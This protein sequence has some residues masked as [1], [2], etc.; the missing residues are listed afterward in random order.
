MPGS[1]L[2]VGHAICPRTYVGTDYPAYLRHEP[3]L[4]PE[5]L[6]ELREQLRGGDM[7]EV[8]RTSGLGCG[9]DLIDDGRHLALAP[10]GPLVRDDLTVLDPQYRADV[11]RRPD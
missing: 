4:H 9:F 1:A 7:P 2:E 11:E 8:Q 3:L 6:G 5:P 10:T